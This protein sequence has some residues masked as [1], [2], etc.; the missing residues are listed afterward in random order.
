MNNLSSYCGLTD[1]RISASDTDLPVIVLKG[2]VKKF[3][4]K[5]SDP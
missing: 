3:R 5:A 4:M 1:L 2:W